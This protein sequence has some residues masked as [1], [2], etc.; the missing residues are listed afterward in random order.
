M[1]TDATITL[2]KDIQAIVE[3]IEAGDVALTEEL[4][5]TFTDTHTREELLNRASLILQGIGPFVTADSQDADRR[6]K[7][8]QYAKHQ[9][10]QSI[11]E[12]IRQNSANVI[13]KITKR[14]IELHQDINRLKNNLDTIID[15]INQ[16]LTTLEGIKD[17]LQET[18]KNIEKTDAKITDANDAYQDNKT[19][20]EEH[21][22]AP[23]KEAL[24]EIIEC[25][26]RLVTIEIDIEGVKPSRRHAVYKD[27]EGEYYI[28]HPETGENIPIT[29]DMRILTDPSNPESESYSALDDIAYQTREDSSKNF[30]NAPG[31]KETVDQ[32]N[33]NYKIYLTAIEKL[34]KDFPHLADL[35][36][37]MLIPNR[38]MRSQ[39][40]DLEKLEDFKKSL[41]ETIERLQQELKA[42][43][44]RKQG[45]ETELNQKTQKLAAAIAELETIQKRDQELSSRAERTLKN[46]TDSRDRIEAVL[47]DREEIDTIFAKIETEFFDKYDG[48]HAQMMALYAGNLDALKDPENHITMDGRNVSRASSDIGDIKEGDLYF[49]DPE[50]RTRE[51]ITDPL[52]KA[53]LY[54]AAYV[55]GKVFAN[56]WQTG[57]NEDPQNTWSITRQAK[58]SPKN[59]AAALN[60]H[61]VEKQDEIVKEA[62]ED[63]QKAEAE[64]EAFQATTPD[65][66]VRDMTTAFCAAANAQPAAEEEPSFNA[67]AASI[68]TPAAP[69]VASAQELTA[70]ANMG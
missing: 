12:I 52:T 25:S 6:Q 33:T 3:A 62:E 54:E 45:I 28:K 29:A 63:L 66:D 36:E 61:V 31:M 44:V 67:N 11:L 16:K 22:S 32:Y 53:R 49:F 58:L 60:V 17:A 50:T 64:A 35:R 9:A 18:G 38:E 43:E 40:I 47:R 70:T 1:A 34:I 2:N 21:L 69:S 14:I 39:K 46:L 57:D 51:K 26:K 65:P 27:D 55:N 5:N 42:L 8:Q 48:R 10:V 15:Q 23:G 13:A 4:V 24:K 37:Q 68:C 30:A 41:E 7:Q 56:E 19:N 59:I 20:L